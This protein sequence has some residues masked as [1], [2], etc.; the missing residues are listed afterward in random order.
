MMDD[1][2]P[3]DT[4]SDFH[5]SGN[6]RK[7]YVASEIVD[8]DYAPTGWDNWLGVPMEDS[9]R[10]YSAGYL[11]SAG[12]ILGTGPWKKAK[13][14]G[15]T[16]DTFSTKTSQ[17]DNAGMNGPV[18]R[19]EVGDMIEIYFVNKMPAHYAALHS[20]GLSYNKQN[21]GSL[22]PTV[23]VP[24][25]EEP[26]I[27]GDAVPPGGCYVY[28]WVVPQSSGPIDGSNSALR[29]YHNYVNLGADINAGLQGPTIIY[30]SGKMNQTMATN[31][32]LIFLF[33]IYHE[34]KSFLAGENAAAAGVS[35][36]AT[37]SG[38]NPSSISGLGN[39]TL[40]HPQLTNTPSVSLSTSQAPNFHTINGYVFSNAPA[41]EM[42]QADGVIWYTY[43]FG[44]ASHVFH[45]HGNNFQVEGQGRWAASHSLNDGDMVALTMTAG[46]P[47]VWNAI[48]HVDNHLE[49]GMLAPYKVQPSGNCTL[50]PLASNDDYSNN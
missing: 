16:D 3:P 40:W 4:P 28:K 14:V 48:C 29:A 9:P 27:P 21:E 2:I 37:Y 32:E 11:E 25:V 8:W 44:S 42:C 24:G 1:Q 18:M 12:S 41:F 7:Y 17:P 20:M 34:R 15:Y 39:H 6:I 23:L 49:R 47:G 35:A 13:Y 19:A 50:P 30:A 31:R 33:N 22:Y 36:S 45:L 5:F 43:A 46:A 10:A 26:V 38:P